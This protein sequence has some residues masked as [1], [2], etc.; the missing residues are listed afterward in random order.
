MIFPQS[1]Q[2]GT[3]YYFRRIL[4]IHLFCHNDLFTFQ[5]CTCVDDTFLVPIESAW[6]SLGRQR[7][8][9][10]WSS[11]R[12]DI[13]LKIDKYI[14]FSCFPFNFSRFEHIESLPVIS[15]FWNFFHAPIWVLPIFGAHPFWG[16]HLLLIRPRRYN[17]S[18][19]NNQKWVS[20]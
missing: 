18:H 17:F 7:E 13:Y 20:K 3:L 6:K 9:T 16:S 2:R 14:Y 4:M 12:R 5:F 15:W 19:M 11:A 10:V 8:I 1:S